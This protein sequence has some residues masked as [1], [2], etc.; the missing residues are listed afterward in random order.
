MKMAYRILV[1][2][3]FAGY[4]VASYFWIAR[5]VEGRGIFYNP[6][7][8]GEETIPFLPQTFF[9][10]ILCYVVPPIMFLILPNWKSLTSTFWAFLTGLWIHKLIWLLFPVKYDL[11]PR[12]P[13][14]V[15]DPLLS[16]ANR[17]F[18]LDSPPVNCFPSL[19]VS[20]I[21]LTY[22]AVAAYRPRYAPLFFILAVAISLS[23]LTFK[24]HYVMDVVTGI[25]LA[26][27]L[28]YL[29]LKPSVDI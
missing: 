16:L 11:R 23:T 26:L 28:K 6:V 1:M 7:L 27:L 19:H 25:V 4:F 5:H 17:F 22:F 3:L 29:F 8:P 2:F 15:A 9:I 12:I 21:F 13:Q 18:A 20:Y 10:Y 24:Q 14:M